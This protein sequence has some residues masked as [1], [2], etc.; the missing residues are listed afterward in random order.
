MPTRF[1][2][3]NATPTSTNNWVSIIGG[4][5]LDQ[6]AGVADHTNGDIYTV[7]T[8]ASQTAGTQDILLAKY[9]SIGILQWQRTI[10][11]TLADVAG[12]IALDS[13]GNPHI[14]A[15]ANSVGTAGGNDIYTI[16][17]DTTGALTW[18]RMIGGASND[19]GYGIVVDSAGNV[20]IT[21]D[22]GT[23]TG[24][25]G[26]SDILLVKYNSAGTVQFQ[27]SVGGTGYDG[28]RGV[29][30]DSAGN[31]YMS[32]SENSTGSPAGNNFFLAKYNSTGTLQWQRILGGANDDVCLGVSIDSSDNIYSFGY[33]NSATAGVT[34]DM[35]ILKY[36]TSGNLIWQKHIS[37]NS[38][39]NGD[40]AAGLGIDST[41]NIYISG[42][43]TAA[44]QGGAN[45]LFIIKLNSSGSLIWE[46]TF[47]GTGQDYTSG[48]LRYSNGFFY[49]S[50]I[51]TGFGLGAVGGA[52]ESLLIKFSDDG[53]GTGTYGGLVYAISAVATIT[54]PTYTN[55]TSTL[56][57]NTRTLAAST[58]T[59]VSVTTRTIPVATYPLGYPSGPSSAGGAPTIT[60][61]NILR[62]TN[63]TIGTTQL[64]RSINTL[65]NTVLQKAYFGSYVSS[66]LNADQ[67][68]GGGTIIF[69]NADTITNLS[70]NFWI[71]ALNI[72]VW[73]PSTYTKVGTVRD[74]T[75]TSL[76]GSEATAINSIQVTHI[77]GITTT[78]V[79]AL[80][81]D[82]IVFEIWS[83][84]TQGAATAYSIG[85]YFDG[86]TVNTV[87]NT[88]VTSQ[89][90][91]IELTEN[92][93]FGTLISPS[94][95]PLGMLGF[96]GL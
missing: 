63:T 56:T 28:G 60:L 61:D 78:A 34:Y 38:A 10:G 1:Y 76:G 85:H 32:G 74:N 23:A 46:R 84:F 72:Y 79:S 25:A 59:L 17:Y 86:T 53:T 55:Q 89:A 20:Y 4:T 69:N 36:D 27:V 7:S 94:F 18:Q 22:A 80:A 29:A 2:L 66:T 67:T 92:L 83:A 6:G 62:T 73:R 48:N 9:S 70:A 19:D 37:Y 87:E 5:A 40:V 65:A 71:N 45:D 15:R 54:T 47:G 43:T 35:L 30:L 13:S 57:V 68:V 39:V 58:P 12:G 49:I 64:V 81:G 16:K 41:G 91:F 33:S 96:F 8:E 21:G 77:T 52:G 75:T 82:I 31:I 50:G 26:S 95:D 93:T 11:G 24:G 51:Q 44:P 42:H 88:V 14:V 3:H 90:S